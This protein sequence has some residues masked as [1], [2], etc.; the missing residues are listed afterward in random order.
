ML[1]LTKAK[2]DPER[3]YSRVDVEARLN[4]E[5]FHLD[6]K[7]KDLLKGSPFLEAVDR[8]FKEVS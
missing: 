3:G 1:S 5:Y 2:G 4:E 6:A 7:L 8:E